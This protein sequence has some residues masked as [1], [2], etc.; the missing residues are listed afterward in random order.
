MLLWWP[1]VL[2]WFGLNMKGPKLASE[3]DFLSKLS[4]NKLQEN[5]DNH[6]YYNTDEKYGFSDDLNEFKKSKL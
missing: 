4:A 6:R 5:A 1:I 3:V 2:K